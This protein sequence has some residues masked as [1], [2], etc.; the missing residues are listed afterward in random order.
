[1]K[2]GNLR[3]KVPNP[4]VYASED[5]ESLEISLRAPPPGGARFFVVAGRTAAQLNLCS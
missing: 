2:P 3:S 5:E 4:A 1:M